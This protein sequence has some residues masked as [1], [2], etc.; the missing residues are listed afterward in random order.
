MICFPTVFC[1]FILITI[2][3]PGRSLVFIWTRFSRPFRSTEVHCFAVT[4][5][6]LINDI[7]IIFCSYLI[8]RFTKE[9]KQRIFSVES[10]SYL[11]DLSIRRSFSLVSST[12]GKFILILISS[13]WI[14]AACVC[15]WNWG[16]LWLL[17]ILLKILLI[18]L[19]WYPFS[20]NTCFILAFSL[21]K[22][23]LFVIMEYALLN[24]EETT[25]LC[26]PY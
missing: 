20:F 14:S 7:V 11:C 25:C 12:Y 1:N 23:S 22:S 5:V 26:V 21:C 16:K 15:C 8:F 4:T 9:F 18:M 10:W 24:K 6:N 13:S 3:I 17:V 19:S 2:A